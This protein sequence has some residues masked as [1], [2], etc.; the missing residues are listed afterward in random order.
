MSA[1]ASERRWAWPPESRRTG[2]RDRIAQS[3][4]VEHRVGRFG[5]VVVRGEE[6]QQLERSQP[7]VEAAGLAASRRSAGGAGDR[8]A[9][10]RARARAPFPRRDGG[11][12]RGSRPW[13]SCPRRSVRASPNTSPAPTSKSSSSTAS[14][15]PYD[16]RSPATEIALVPV[17]ALRSPA[18]RR[19][20]PA[21]RATRG[22]SRRAAPPRA[23]R[24]PRRRVA[25]SRPRRRRPRR[26]ARRAPAARRRRRR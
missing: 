11:S 19:R 25:R 8:R 24:V 26:C 5:V 21:R 20:P 12:P 18:R 23:R 3:D 7:R 9:P 10:D 16:F 13:W 6:A 22:P 4:E 1:H 17:S 14:V 15:D 2:V